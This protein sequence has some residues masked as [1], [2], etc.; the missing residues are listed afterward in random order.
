M[1]TIHADKA[2][3]LLLGHVGENDCTEVVFSE[4]IAAWLSEYPN[5]TIG[6]IN[7]P[8]RQDDGY[9]VANIQQTGSVVMWTIKAADLSEEGRGQCQLV[10]VQDSIIKKS[11]YWDTRVMPSLKPSGTPPSPEDEWWLELVRLKSEAVAAAQAAEEAASHYPKIVDGYWVVWDVETEAYISTGIEAQGPQ[12]NPGAVFTP[13]VSDQGVISWENNGGLPNPQSRNIKGPAGAVYTPSV[14]DHGVISWTND[15]GLPNPPDKNIKGTPGDDGISPVITV[16]TITGGHRV[17]I[18]DADHP[19][20]QT[21]DVMDGVNGQDGRGIVSIEKTDTSGFVDTYTITYTTGSPTTFTVTNGVNA[22]V[23]LRWASH[24]PTQDSDLSTTP[25]PWMGVYSGRSATAPEHYTD[26]T[27]NNVQGP[28]GP[29]GLAFTFEDDGTGL[30][31][32]PL[33]Q[34]A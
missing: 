23:W 3:T 7:R 12:G 2:N 33:E 5:A 14:S 17:T 26:Y 9:P 20:G 6:I 21:I 27:W 34:E 16:E 18:V 13:S 19:Q 32:E 28:Q 24:E 31:L 22:Y 25:G 29:Q 1:V 11:A 30:I 15:G 8:A 4:I 10:A